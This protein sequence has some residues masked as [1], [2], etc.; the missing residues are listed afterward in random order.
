[1]VGLN[2]IKVRSRQTGA[3][4]IEFALLFLLFFVLFYAMVSYALVFMLQN[5]IVHAAEE[6][7]RAA[8]SVDPLAYSS[9]SSYINNGIVPTVR[10]TVGNSL[11]WLPAKAKSH[12]LGV[13]NGNVQVSVSNGVLTVQVA[14]PNYRSDPLLPVLNFPGFGP[15]I[16]QSLQGRAILRLS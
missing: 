2:S 11:D 13:G 14:Y 7:A 16:P 15:I 1:M 4:A 10:S 9:S 12:A 3:A 8:I 6:G 5:A